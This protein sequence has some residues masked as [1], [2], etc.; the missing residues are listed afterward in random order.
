MVPTIRQSA[1]VTVAAG[2]HHAINSLR[3]SPTPMRI[4]SAPF[5]PLH[6]TPMLPIPGDVVLGMIQ[7][8]VTLPVLSVV[9]GFSPGAWPILPSG[10]VYVIA[11][12]VAG[13]ARTAT[14]A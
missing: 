10:I 9:F 7:V 12:C 11:H 13:A 14:D 3:Y 5:A 8:Q 1:H 2:M 4:R 6:S